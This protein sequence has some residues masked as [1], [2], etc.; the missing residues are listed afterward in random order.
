MG[1]NWTKEQTQVINSR[2]RNLLVSAAAGSGKTAVLVER[3]IRM[4]TDEKNPV[5]IDR[6]LVMTFTKA[7]ASE[8]RE[9]IQAALEKKL[10]ENPQ[11][12]HL[13]QQAVMVQYAQVTTIDS[14]CLHI[15]REHFDRLDID[16]AFRVSD[17]GELLL[18]KSEVME[19]LLEDYYAKEGERFKRFVDTYSI[20]KA[21]G[22]ISDYIS[23]VYTFS[24]SNP[25]PEEWFENCRKELNNVTME[26]FEQTGW[27]R[28][29][30]R[31]IH[32]QAEEWEQQLGAAAAICREADG[33]EPYLPMILKDLEDIR[34]VEGAASYEALSIAAR[35]IEFPKLAPI[36]AANSA[37]NPE[38][39]EAVS[40]CRKRVK[41]A[42][43][44]IK[45]QYLFESVSEV[46]SDLEDSRESVFMLLE[47]AE[48]Y[49]KRYQQKKQEKNRVD[50]NDLEHFALNIL[51][52][53]RETED[54][55]GTEGNTRRPGAVAD[56]IS[57]QYDE[58]LVDEYQ[59]SNLVQETLIKS[60]SRERFGH[61][62]V[63][64]VGDVKQSIYKF[65]LARPE[66]FLE[67]YHSYSLEDSLFQK[68]ELHQNFRSRDTVLFSI[69]DVFERI[70]TRRLGDIDY[71][72]ETALHPGIT[73]AEGAK[74][75]LLN[76]EL[77]L[78]NTAGS[79]LE[80]LDEDVSDYTSREL[81]AGMIAGKIKELA[82]FTVWDKDEECYRTA[83]YSDMVILLRSTS[84]WADTF[85][86]VLSKQGIPAFAESR[87]GYFD[88]PEVET[89]LNFLAVIDN[90]I[91]DIPLA[92]VLKAPFSGLSDGE[93]AHVAALYK[94]KAEKGRDRG[95]Y[96][97]VMSYLKEGAEERENRPCTIGED[98]LFKKLSHTIELIVNLRSAA[99][100]LPI[101]ELL[102]RIYK[103][104]GY[105]DY[106]SAMPS[107]ETR[108]ANLDML[109]EKA[110]AYEAT[111]YRGVF[112]FI[113]YIAK[114]KRY[115]SD[116]GGASTKSEHGDTV[117]IMSIHKSK[118]LEFPIVFVAGMG[119]LFNKQD[120]R[121]KI[122][123]DSEYGIGTDYLDCEKRLKGPTLKKNV[124]KRRMDLEAL[125]EELRVL[126]VAMTRAKE[127]LILTASDKNLEAKLL[128]WNHIFSKDGKVPYTVLTMAGSYLDWILMSM[129]EG[130]SRICMKEVRAEALLNREIEEQLY[131]RNA[132]E[133]L[134]HFDV[135]RSYHE[136]Y[137]EKLIKSFGF[138]YPHAADIV[139]NTKLS[140]SELKKEGTVQQDEE[141]AFLP[142]IPS[143]MEE[144]ERQERG[145][146][147]GTA[148]HRVMELLPFGELACE[149]DTADYIA[150]LVNTGKM[151]AEAGAMVEAGDIYRFLASGLG[152][153]MAEAEKNGR[154]FREKQFVMSVTA[155][156]VGD[157]D[158]DEPVLIQGIIDAYFEEADG[159]VLVDY[160]TD[161]VKDGEILK[162]R[163]GAQLDYYER[164]LVQIIEKPVKER[165]I[166]SYRLGSIN[167]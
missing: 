150:S 72:E 135:N 74:T 33:P 57:G 38:K 8:M 18:M 50:F 49:A 131:K 109:A 59:D 46:L 52:E 148:Y 119:K 141:M 123:I 167:M 94:N 7:A 34:G 101:H 35:Q 159:L 48:E 83:R 160:K 9:R 3:I 30:L 39:K 61:P 144:E 27:M 116:F 130:D 120:M 64:M 163:Y 99:V 5:D 11:D 108:R 95:L 25:W 106:V 6:L 88:S 13:Q 158:S 22:G 41:K 47:L 71:T 115:N 58:I 122:L 129:A 138:I 32:M 152:K 102:Y 29:L 111:S 80:Q 26:E 98:E 65:R 24:Q 10:E 81:E 78:M 54:E 40:D 157:W 4:I 14:F 17:E 62:N 105:Y 51:M 104:T 70:M 19:T 155:R 75:E 53:K 151:T 153:R 139:L 56:E 28:F 16:P 112:H 149:K 1:V 140:V 73:F 134:L 90:P 162:K 84:G 2:D 142:T 93:L 55:G 43:E 82:E 96:G 156:E 121:G 21:D 63:F 114:L 132:K 89:M 147:R 67:K 69:N 137:R 124:L 66:L 127:K 20:G 113:K 117:R 107:G 44:K 60:I 23:Q 79:V 77:L 76:T 143:F 118:G 36:R 146:S 128:K 100:Y 85:T 37:V 68:I 31:D 97:A 125:G 92:S 133:E 42:V 145:A 161:Y 164:A 86:E 154:L 166:Y 45:E 87:T 15:L 136:G 91:Q 12:E 126:Y 165:V 103:E 110:S